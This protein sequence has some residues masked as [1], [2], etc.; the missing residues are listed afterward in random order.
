MPDAGETIGAAY[1]GRHQSLATVIST[2]D[3]LSLSDASSDNFGWTA[4]NK[5]TESQGF[6]GKDYPWLTVGTLVEPHTTTTLRAVN[7]EAQMTKCSLKWEL[8]GN[9]YDGHEH[10]IPAHILLAHALAPYHLP[11]PELVL[12]ARKKSVW[13]VSKTSLHIFK[14]RLVSKTSLHTFKVIACF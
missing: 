3:E 1:F 6:A 13:L 11:Q 8:L 4:H 10:C 7:V 9:A 14:T 2:G 5:Y 12:Y